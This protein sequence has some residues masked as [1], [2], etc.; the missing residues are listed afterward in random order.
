MTRI[1][2]DTNV[3]VSGMIRPFGPP[4][5]I[6]DLV[7]EGL[8]SLAIDDRIFAE[9]C[10]VLK[11]PRFRRYFSIADVRNVVRYLERNTSYSVCTLHASDLPDPAD[12]PFLEVALASGVPLVTG[13]MDHF[14]EDRR[15]GV[16]VLSPAE[17]L[18][19]FSRP[20]T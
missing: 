12:A 7:R 5:R 20:A 8:L 13:N 4:G 2:L 15:R 3:L 10:E 17:F 1:V 11:R 14:P 18:L 6:V 9:Y 16:D 19:R